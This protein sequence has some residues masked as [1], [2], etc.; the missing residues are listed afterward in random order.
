MI[1]CH[2]S[3]S[4]HQS[5]HGDR[6][7]IGARAGRSQRDVFLAL[8]ALDRHD[9]DAQPASHRVEA[10]L[11][12]EG[13][14]LSD[15]DKDRRAAVAGKP[16]HQSV[17]QGDRRYLRLVQVQEPDVAL[18]DRRD[19]VRDLRGAHHAEDRELSVVDVSKLHGAVQY[20]DGRGG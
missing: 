3:A 13:A 6:I 20:N 5:A 18:L 17:G 14:A 19:Q 9:D 15:V 10:K 12:F 7:F 1:V 16:L 11:R 8:G 4:I 2:Q